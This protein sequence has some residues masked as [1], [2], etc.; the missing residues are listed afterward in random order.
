[1]ADWWCENEEETLLLL[2]ITTKSS[3]FLWIIYF[4]SHNTFKSHFNISSIYHVV[5]KLVLMS[6]LYDVRL[7]LSAFHINI[8]LF[9]N[10]IC[11]LSLCHARL[12]HNCAFCMHAFFFLF[13]FVILGTYVAT[14][15]RMT[16]G[17]SA[18]SLYF[19]I[20]VIHRKRSDPFCKDVQ[21][22]RNLSSQRLR[23]PMPVMN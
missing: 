10:W 1:M 21:Y 9:P 19:L 2:I 22:C 3:H 20:W 13:F 14:Q 6:S 18:T 4:D 8:W 7:F 23:A 12:R 16:E 17:F 15:G 11:F 5:W